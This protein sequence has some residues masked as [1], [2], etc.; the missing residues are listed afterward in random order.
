MIGDFRGFVAKP[1][2]R[3]NGWKAW[4]LSILAVNLTFQTR[5]SRLRVF[6]ANQVNG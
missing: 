1:G 5:P 4:R 3:V 2:E 6:L